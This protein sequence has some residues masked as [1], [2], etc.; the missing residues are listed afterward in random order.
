MSV[1]VAESPKV[2]LE[3]YVR[4]QLNHAVAILD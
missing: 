1:L 3:Q 2:E 4:L